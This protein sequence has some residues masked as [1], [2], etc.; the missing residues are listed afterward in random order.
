[1]MRDDSTVRTTV[2]LDADLLQIAKELASARQATMGR[3]LSDLV[4]KALESSDTH[5]TRNGVPLLPRRPR[6]SAL[7]TMKLVNEFRDRE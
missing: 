3:V 2:D 7:P 5:T 6:G 4:R 1:M